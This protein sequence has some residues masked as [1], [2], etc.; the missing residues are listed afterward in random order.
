[1]FETTPLNQLFRLDALDAISLDSS[2]Q[3]NLFES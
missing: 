1:M 2:S 3:L